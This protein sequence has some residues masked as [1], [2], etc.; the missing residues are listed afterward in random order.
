MCMNALNVTTL[1]NVPDSY[2]LVPTA[3][4]EDR[5]VSWVPDGRVASKIMCEFSR[6]S[7]GCGIP[8]FDLGVRR[9]RENGAFVKVTPFDAV[10]FGGVGR[11]DL[12]WAL[13]WGTYIPQSDVSISTSAQ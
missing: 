6:L 11:N 1:A 4:A 8:Y 2:R 9:A 12:D 7:H 3:A 13:L 5:L 10:D